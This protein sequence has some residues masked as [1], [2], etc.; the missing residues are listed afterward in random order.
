MTTTRRPYLTPDPNT[1]PVFLNMRQARARTGLGEMTLRRMVEQGRFPRPVRLT[2]QRVAWRT[3][4]VEAW[5]A[6]RVE[7]A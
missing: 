4:D 2:Q 5:E 3:A 1:A 7:V 6:S